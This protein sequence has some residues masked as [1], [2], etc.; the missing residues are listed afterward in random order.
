MLAASSWNA[1]LQLGQALCR[2]TGGIHAK[3]CIDLQCRGK[4]MIVLLNVLIEADRSQ[5]SC[6]QR[7]GPTDRTLVHYRH[8]PT[9]LRQS[10]Q[11]MSGTR[12]PGYFASCTRQPQHSW[13]KHLLAGRLAAAAPKGPQVDT[14]YI[15]WTANRHPSVHGE[16]AEGLSKAASGSFQKLRQEAGNS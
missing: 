8:R 11:V 6:Q 16:R 7:H 15:K 10:Q 1:C 12:G 9:Q 2:P 4:S 5:H 3:T 13:Q 14:G